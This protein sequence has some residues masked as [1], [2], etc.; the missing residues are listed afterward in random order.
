MYLY[1]NNDSDDSYINI[2]NSD[3]DSV[4]ELSGMERRDWINLSAYVI[5]LVQYAWLRIQFSPNF[6]CNLTNSTCTQFSVFT[7]RRGFLFGC[8]RFSNDSYVWCKPLVSIPPFVSFSQFR[9]RVILLFSWHGKFVWLMN[10][11][12][13]RIYS[14]SHSI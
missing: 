12:N 7:L 14:L 2:E 6:R 9:T 5:V 11:N 10:I 8:R 1:I 13:I 3:Y 4:S